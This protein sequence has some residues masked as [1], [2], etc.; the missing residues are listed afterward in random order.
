VGSRVITPI[1]ANIQM[2]DKCV[3]NVINLFIGLLIMM[4]LLKLNSIDL[5]TNGGGGVIIT[6]AIRPVEQQSKEREVGVVTK[7]EI[8]KNLDNQTL[9]IIMN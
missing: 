9:K 3:R 8:I 2:K 1:L 6:D 4:I 5:V 7:E